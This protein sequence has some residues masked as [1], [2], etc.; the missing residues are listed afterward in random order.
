LEGLL[1]EEDV[2]CNIK[3]EKDDEGE[4][5]FAQNNY[6]GRGTYRR[7]RSRRG[8]RRRFNSQ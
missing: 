3:E 2:S 1:L 8:V 4:V 6:R 7:G 5:M